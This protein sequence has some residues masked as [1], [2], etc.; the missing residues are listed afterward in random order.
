MSLLAGV[1]LQNLLEMKAKQIMDRILSHK[2][3]GELIG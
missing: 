1:N 3:A 2:R